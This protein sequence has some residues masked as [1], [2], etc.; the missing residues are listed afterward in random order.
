MDP[1]LLLVFCWMSEGTSLKPLVARVPLIL[2]ILSPRDVLGLSFLVSAAVLGFDGCVV[3]DFGLEVGEVVGG[4]GW[5]ALDDD[6]GVGG[7]GFFVVDVLWVGQMLL[8]LLF[9]SYISSS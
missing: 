1:S 8:L 6:A 2:A 5:D 3:V 7:D 4:V 9:S